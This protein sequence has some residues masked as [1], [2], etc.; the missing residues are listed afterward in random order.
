MVANPVAS[1]LV[2][3]RRLFRRRG[4]VPAAVLVAAILTATRVSGA[5]A[6]VPLLETF[7][8]GVTDWTFLGGVPGTIAWLPSNHAGPA[9]S[10]SAAITNTARSGTTQTVFLRC[11]TGLAGAGQYAIGGFILIP[12]GQSRHGGGELG[13]DFFD[14]AT[15]TG[16]AIENLQT[17]TFV[18]S[19]NGGW[20][21]V[22]ARVQAPAGTQSAALRL[23]VEKYAVDPGENP[24]AD[25]T[26]QF[27]G[28]FMSNALANIARLPLLGR[29]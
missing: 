24:A 3:V 7:D 27:D 8:A 16:A 21:P 6:P 17:N 14:N 13:I 25:F 4:I 28:L 22:L 23:S 20:A 11:A 10:G 1:A 2:H 18:T 19:S 26:A 15:C 9:G 5:S 29:D 12:A